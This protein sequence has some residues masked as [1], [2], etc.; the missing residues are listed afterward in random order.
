MQVKHLQHL[1]LLHIIVLSSPIPH[2]E[3]RHHK[4]KG[5]RN[6]PCRSLPE[7]RKFLD[8]SVEFLDV[9]Y[10]YN[11]NCGGGTSSPGGGLLG[12]HLQGISHVSNHFQLG[13]RPG[14]GLLGLGL[15]N[16]LFGSS[17]A[18]SSASSGATST[19]ISVPQDPVFPNSAGRPR[20]NAANNMINAGVVSGIPDRFRRPG[21]YVTVSNS[22]LGSYTQDI[23]NINPNRIIRQ[24]NREI[25]QLLKPLYHIL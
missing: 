13:N 3:A 9:N 7:G 23:S 21:Q 20:P 4:N 19:G 1:I 17:S 2:D 22:L 10:N 15:G 12:S 14:G 5:T 25:D 8:L 11:Y 16:L 24:F 18:Q 6:R